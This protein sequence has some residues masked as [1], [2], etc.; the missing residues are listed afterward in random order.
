MVLL[1]DCLPELN[2]Q[3][4]GNASFF[5]SFA[6]CTPCAVRPAVDYSHNLISFRGGRKTIKILFVVMNVTLYLLLFCAFFLFLLFHILTNIYQS[7][8]YTNHIFI[9]LFF[10]LVFLYSSTLFRPLIF[11]IQSTVDLSTAKNNSS[12]ITEIETILEKKYFKKKIKL[13]LS[14]ILLPKT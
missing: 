9:F 1:P 10:G 12:T 11:S 13:I 4:A 14:E 3:L 8:L 6:V 7:C 2:W 5:Y